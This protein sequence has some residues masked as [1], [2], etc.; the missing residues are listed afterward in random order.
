[1]YEEFAT[2]DLG[3]YFPMSML[4]MVMKSLVSKG[5]EEFY[6]NVKKIEV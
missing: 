5:V 2:F 6:T 1:M 4:N 3:G